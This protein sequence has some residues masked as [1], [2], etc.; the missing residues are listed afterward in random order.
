MKEKEYGYSKSIEEIEVILAKIERGET[1]IDDLLVEIKRA[2]NL[3]HE[4]RDK[5][6]KTEQEVGKILNNDE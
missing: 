6:L 5:L 2:T 3:L 4:C 1:D